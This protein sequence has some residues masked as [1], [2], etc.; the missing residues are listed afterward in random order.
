MQTVVESLVGQVIAQ[1]IGEAT[2]LSCVTTTLYDLIAA[3]HDIVGSNDGT[4]V[5]ATIDHMLRAG[6]IA[7]L[8][9]GMVLD[10][11]QGLP[12]G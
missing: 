2:G 7:F 8:D 4:V 11:I 3:M 6:R 12:F 10:Q 9:N 5:V 1:E